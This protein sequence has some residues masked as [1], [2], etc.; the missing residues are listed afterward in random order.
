[1]YG[2]SCTINAADECRPCGGTTGGGGTTY[3]KIIGRIWND[4]DKNGTYGGVSELWSNTATTCSTYKNDSFNIQEAG[5]N[6]LAS[7]AC[8][9]EWGVQAAYYTSSDIVIGSKTITLTG[10]PSGYA[11]GSWSFS[12]TG[13]TST[14]DGTGCVTTAVPI[15][16]GTNNHLWWRIVKTNIAPTLSIVPSSV[17]YS[18][19]ALH[20]LKIVAADGEPYGSLKISTSLSPPNNGWLPEVPAIS[21]RAY[22]STGDG[23]WPIA[24]I[25]GWNKST[26]SRVELK[27]FN[28][29]TATPTDYW[30]DVPSPGLYSFF[31]LEFTNDYNG[32]VGKDV[33][34]YVDNLT[35]IADN[36]FY[37]TLYKFEA[38]DANLVQYD[39]YH[40][41][42]GYGLVSPSTATSSVPGATYAVMAWNG[43]LRFPVANP[44]V[45]TASHTPV[46]TTGIVT[47]TAGGTNLSAPLNS[48]GQYTVA[49]L[50]GSIS[51]LCLSGLP[52]T[53]A[54]RIACRNGVPVSATTGSCDY[55]SPSLSGT[56]T[57]TIDIG[58]RPITAKGWLAAMGSDLYAKDVVESLPPYTGC[59]F[60]G[61]YYGMCPTFTETHPTRIPDHY[62]LNYNPWVATPASSTVFTEDDV[63]SLGPSLDELSESG[64]SATR[65]GSKFREKNKQYFS[66]FHSLI[67]TLKNAP[68]GTY[69]ATSSLSNRTFT[70]NS[71]TIWNAGTSTIPAPAIG[72]YSYT[73]SDGLA[74][75]V[76]PRNGPSTNAININKITTSGA[77]R[78]VILADRDINIGSS[79]VGSSNNLKND[80]A[81]IQASIITT[82]NVT[83]NNY[84]SASSSAGTVIIEGP[85]IIGGGTGMTINRSLGT[86]NEFRPAVFVRFNPLYITKLND[87]AMKNTIPALNPLFTFDF[88]SETE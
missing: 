77:G 83:V 2:I 87:L 35:Y 14:T 72:N 10:L 84:L 29:N 74:F 61:N 46:L 79:A 56:G 78:L 60:L 7:W 24:K 12:K 76:I 45:C 38:E 58:I 47:A 44:A 48:F 85:L 80:T 26:G 25:Y 11:C 15:I 22:G 17:S 57:T 86:D 16:E 39:R 30:F 4:V 88:T 6:R 51:Q 64:V 63:V 1:Y 69:S 8:N 54:Y 81:D 82:G 43:A 75:L 34:L 33:N 52:A 36:M 13:D 71:I 20:P 62:V 67:D 18:G 73:V 3:G 37:Q 40:P 9:T 19:Y 59:P 5:T 21:F 41:D 50:F 31:D 68:T 28:I 70:K 49:G 42:D 32:G 53:P 23:I 65:V 27:T 66:S 55:I